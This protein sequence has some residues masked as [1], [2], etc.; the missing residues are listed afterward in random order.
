MQ[1]QLF[2]NSL[3]CQILKKKQKKTGGPPTCTQW[4]TMYKQN[5][6]EPSAKVCQPVPKSSHERHDCLGLVFFIRIILE[7]HVSLE[8]LLCQKFR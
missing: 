4:G 8:K 1:T 3:K 7:T 5:L 2:P 6:I